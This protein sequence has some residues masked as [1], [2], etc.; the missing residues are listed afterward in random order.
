M[1]KKKRRFAGMLSLIL[2]CSMMLGQC[3]LIANAD[4][5]MNIL[6]EEN[7]ELIDEHKQEKNDTVN[8]VEEADLNKE[9]T[10]KEEKTEEEVKYN[11]N[12]D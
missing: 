10:I 9:N 4:D 3:K 11:Y 8:E 7:E 1:M 6:A 12:N 2:I 5:E